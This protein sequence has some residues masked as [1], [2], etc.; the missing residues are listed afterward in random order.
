MSTY[1]KLCTLCTTVAHAQ[2]LM[3]CQARFR[4]VYLAMFSC[5]LLLYHCVS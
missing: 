4:N 3:K 5:L 1:I 2:S